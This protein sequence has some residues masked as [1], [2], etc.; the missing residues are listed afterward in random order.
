MANYKVGDEVVCIVTGP[1]WRDFLIPGKKYVVTDI[2]GLCVELEGFTN[3]RLDYM[4]RCSACGK[5]TNYH[6]HPK[7]WQ[8]IKL[9]GL[10]ED[11]TTENEV[12]A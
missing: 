2:S 7:T 1:V 11:Q 6:W 3:G 5:D 12:T 8:F 9:D 10:T 4:E